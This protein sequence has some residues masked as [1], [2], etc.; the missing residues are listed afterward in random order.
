MMIPVAMVQLNEAHPSLG[1]SA[2]QQAVGSERTVARP[3]AVHI[4]N[5]LRLFAHIHQ[6]GYAGLHPERHLILRDTRQDF[7]IAHGPILNPVEI[8]DRLNGVALDAGAQP[9]RVLNVEDRVSD[10]IELHALKLARKEPA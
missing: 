7:R 9:S 4:Q 1:Q 6:F 10:G 5:R 3:G 2:R 8:V